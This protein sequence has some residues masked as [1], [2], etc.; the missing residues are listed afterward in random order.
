MYIWGVTDLV[1]KPGFDFPNGIRSVELRYR[2][3][4]RVV[5]KVYHMLLETC[6]VRNRLVILEMHIAYVLHAPH[7][8]FPCYMDHYD[9]NMMP[10]SSMVAPI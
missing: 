2:R 3:V 5:S 7:L 10:S 9:V 1:S 8:Y 4:R 6:N